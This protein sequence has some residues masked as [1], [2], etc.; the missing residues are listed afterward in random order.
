MYPMTHEQS[1]ACPFTETPPFSQHRRQYSGA[2]RLISTPSAHSHERRSNTFLGPVQSQS[3]FTR[4]AACNGSTRTAGARGGG[5][6][7]S[8]QMRE[9]ALDDGGLFNGRDEFQLPATKRAVLDV[10]VEHA[11]QQLRPTHAPL[12]AAGRR[13]GAIACVR[14]CGL[15]RH[16]HH[17]FSQLRMRCQH[18]LGSQHAFESGLA[19]SRLQ[20]NCYIA[21]PDPVIA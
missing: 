15:S 12:R 19:T 2:T 13:A 21:R 4:Q 10:E 14:R 18:A 6:A 20:D 5:C 8:P 3:V 1:N 16:R 7:V 11:L 9:D 17:R